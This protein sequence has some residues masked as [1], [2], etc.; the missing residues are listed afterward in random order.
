MDKGYE[1][2]YN[3]SFASQLT[4]SFVAVS[5]LSPNLPDSHTAR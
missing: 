5:L 2:D 3:Q 1:V 4:E